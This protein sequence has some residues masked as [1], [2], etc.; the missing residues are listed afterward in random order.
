MPY[1]G[2]AGT[3]GSFGQEAH[4]AGFVALMGHVTHCE[5]QSR[6]TEDAAPVIVLRLILSYDGE[7]YSCGCN[8]SRP[9]LYDHQEFG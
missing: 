6:F 7:V 1:S 5:F 3:N 9:D 2:L 4:A 8:V